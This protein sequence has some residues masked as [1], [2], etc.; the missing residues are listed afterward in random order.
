MDSSYLFIHPIYLFVH[1]FIYLFIYLWIY[2]SIYLFIIYLFRDLFIYLFTN[3]F[4]Y[5]FLYFLF[6]SFENH[7][8]LFGVYQ[9]WNF[10]REKGVSR[11]EEKLGK[12]T[13]A[14]PPKRKYSSYATA[15]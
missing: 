7:L 4:T 3:S 13:F 15:C 12:M 8:N 5:L 9:S 10:Y 11:R 2:L 14:P 1:L 6:F